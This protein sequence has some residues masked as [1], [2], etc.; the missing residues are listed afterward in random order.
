MSL[1]LISVSG[2]SV[3]LLLAIGGVATG[4]FAIGSLAFGVVATGVL[5]FSAL[6]VSPETMQRLSLAAWGLTTAVVT[7][8]VAGLVVV[9]KDRH[10][11][12]TKVE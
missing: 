1:G 9:L 10:P 5:P 11:E 8:G 7:M 12:R 4:G 6:D 3:G 2:F